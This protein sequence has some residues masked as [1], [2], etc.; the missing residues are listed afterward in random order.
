MPGLGKT[1]GARS[2]LQSL[3]RNLMRRVIRRKER[4]SPFL[5]E[6]DRPFILE[7]EGML[8]V[9]LAVDTTVRLSWWL[10]GHRKRRQERREK[11][12]GQRTD[13]R[14][15]KRG[16]ERRRISSIHCLSTP[17]SALAI[18]NMIKGPMRRRAG[19]VFRQ[20]NRYGRSSSQRPVL[21]SITTSS[22]GMAGVSAGFN[23]R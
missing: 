7:E 6:E 4:F 23:G 9:V 17:L 22:S 14:G 15:G 2:F 12:R 13:G 1:G 5:E 16:R 21:P 11:R 8:L 19:R 10:L 18:C 3:M 20:R